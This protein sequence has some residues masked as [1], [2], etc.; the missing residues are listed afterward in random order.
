MEPLAIGNGTGEQVDGLPEVPVGE[1]QVAEVAARGHRRRM[2][3]SGLLEQR[4]RALEMRL[5]D[6]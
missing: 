6:A 3:G 4:H 5:P 1:G 2:V